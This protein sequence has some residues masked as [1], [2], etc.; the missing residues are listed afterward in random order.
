[1]THCLRRSSRAYAI[2]PAAE[3]RRDARE[4]EIRPSSPPPP[5]P[6]CE[7]ID[8]RESKVQLRGAAR[9][10]NYCRS[11]RLDESLVARR[12]PRPDYGRFNALIRFVDG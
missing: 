5:P 4:F 9:E 11:G 12:R 6:R 2:S 7:P 10:I 1:M 3:N 8:R